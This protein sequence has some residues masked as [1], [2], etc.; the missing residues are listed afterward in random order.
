MFFNNS[1]HASLALLVWNIFKFVS[2]VWDGFYCNFLI[3]TWRSNIDWKKSFKFNLKISR[4]SHNNKMVFV[5]EKN[6]LYFSKTSL[7]LNETVI[8]NKLPHLF[9]IFTKKFLNPVDSWKLERLLNSKFFARKVLWCNFFHFKINDL[10]I[11]NFTIGVTYNKG[12]LRTHKK[13]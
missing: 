2:V 7:K 6:H 12:V 4:K 9:C 11:E 10:N 8:F 5:S 13:P 1:L 3:C